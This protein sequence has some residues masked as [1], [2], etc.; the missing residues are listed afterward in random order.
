MPVVEENAASVAE[1]TDLL[2]ALT[3]LRNGKQGVRLP[4][5]WTGLAGRVADAFNDVVELN[6]RMAGELGR[7]S[8]VVG[9][10]HNASRLG[11]SMA[12][13]TALWSQ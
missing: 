9:A 8:S 1:L 5:G 12:S 10:C 11:K 7:L 6:E 4:L 3:A 2:D 13:G